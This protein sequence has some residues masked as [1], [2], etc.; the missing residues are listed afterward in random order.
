M[1]VS[2]VFAFATLAV[3]C[4][5]GT[6]AAPI[7]RV[8]TIAGEDILQGR[9]LLL[10]EDGKENEDNN[11]GCESCY[12]NRF[13]TMSIKEGAAKMKEGFGRLTVTSVVSNLLCMVI[14]GSLCFFG[15]KLLEYIL[16][17]SSFLS[18]Y[19][20]FFFVVSEI[21]TLVGRC[22]C[23]AL[24]L[25]PFAGALVSTYLIR[26]LHKAIFFLMGALVGLSAGHS[27]YVLVLTHLESH[28]SGEY[29]HSLLY[30]GTLSL[31]ALCFGA[32]AVKLESKM[33]AVGTAVIGGPWFS[34]GFWSLLAGLFPKMQKD[35]WTAWSHPCTFNHANPC[36]ADDGSAG[37][38]F[39]GE[40]QDPLTAP[41][42]VPTILAWVLVICGLC[43]QL[44]LQKR[45][46]AEKEASA[47]LMAYGGAHGGSNIGG[48]E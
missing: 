22:N 23:Y 29:T 44:K 2:S 35:G 42:L 20:V 43:T 13:R 18:G 41:V 45:A 33:L 7:L 32:L 15:Y 37:T 39:D 40:P 3:F 6:S 14:G 26:N 8:A 48:R 19:I 38:G 27:F 4:A 46:D 28:M 1:R 11:K 25:V 9:R 12:L 17:I 36:T 34:L 31:S 21:M 5:G 16:L 30:Y 24:G 10:D 47:P